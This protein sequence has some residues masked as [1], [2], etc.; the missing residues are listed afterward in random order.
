MPPAASSNFRDKLA[1]AATET[2]CARMARIKDGKPVSLIRH[3]KSPRWIP[4]ALKT[5]SVFK[6]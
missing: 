2:C 1:A 6:K 4:D 3:D 5:G